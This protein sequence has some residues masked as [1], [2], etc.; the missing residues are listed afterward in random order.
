MIIAAAPIQQAEK[1]PTSDV[2]HGSEAAVSTAK[3]E[4]APRS[5][6]LPSNPKAFASIW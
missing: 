5:T 3:A 6:L 2:D 4:T 1:I